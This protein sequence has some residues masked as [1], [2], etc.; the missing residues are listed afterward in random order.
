M[1][2]QSWFS[3]LFGSK[4][5]S[6][7]KKRRTKARPTFY[8]RLWVEPLEDRLAPAANWTGPVA[9]GNWDTAANWTGGTGA[10]GL[11]GINDDVTI[12]NASVTHSNA[13]TE[14]IKSLSLTSN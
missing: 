14:Q 6:S 9:G 7:S 4:S 13:V 10:N 5:S 12:A 1:S 8:A 3:K 11:P 2:L